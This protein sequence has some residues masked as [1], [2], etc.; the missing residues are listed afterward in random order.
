MGSLDKRKGKWTKG[1]TVKVPNDDNMRYMLFELDYEH[2]EF[3]DLVKNVFWSFELDLLIHKTG[4][5]GYHFI[6]PT[7][8]TKDQWKKI[9]NRLE[10]INKKCPMTCLRMIPNK[11]PNEADIW[12]RTDCIT[13]FE[14]YNF[15]SK[16]MCQYLNKVFG[17]NL[18]GSLDYD[19]NIVSY[20]LP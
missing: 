19:I 11:H 14:N 3:Y 8:I 12:Y 5:G 1:L 4:S 7:V 16:Q 13:H 2:L 20:R 10:N 6:S 18:L 15:N 9:H 17:T